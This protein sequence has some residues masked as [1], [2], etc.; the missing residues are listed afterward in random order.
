[1]KYFD[2]CFGVAHLGSYIMLPLPGMYPTPSTTPQSTDGKQAKP[3]SPTQIYPDEPLE[4]AKVDDPTLRNSESFPMQ[5][6][7]NLSIYYAT[8]EHA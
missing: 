2:Q 4:D 3:P 8:G 5:I 1:M 6:F 7:F